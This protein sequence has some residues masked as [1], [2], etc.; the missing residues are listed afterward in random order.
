MTIPADAR[1]DPDKLGAR[2]AAMSVDEVIE[3]VLA[4]ELPLESIPDGGLR[5]AASSAWSR[6]E[7]ARNLTDERE[8]YLKAGAPAMVVLLD[9]IDD[10]DALVEALPKITV[11]VLVPTDKVDHV[12]QDP[13]REVFKTKKGTETIDLSWR[14]HDGYL[15]VEDLD[16]AEL[17]RIVNEHRRG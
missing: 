8:R 12:E 9:G 3:L 6:Q 11:E 16:Q 10:V 2:L 1:D 4:G 13:E 14:T 5:Q 17:E 7:R 15:I